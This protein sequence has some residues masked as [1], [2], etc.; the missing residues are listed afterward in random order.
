MKMAPVIPAADDSGL[1]LFFGPIIS[2]QS[3]GLSNPQSHHIQ[4]KEG[5][6]L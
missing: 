4:Y 1:W 2:P 3:S 6:I 5:P